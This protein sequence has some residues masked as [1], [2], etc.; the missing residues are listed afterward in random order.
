MC[1]NNPYPNLL[2]DF[3]KE[4][5]CD[6][7]FL[8][9]DPNRKNINSMVKR[10]LYGKTDIEYQYEYGLKFWQLYKN[11]RKF[12]MIVNN[13]GHEGTLEV[14]KYD[15]DIVFNFLNTLYNENLLRDTTILLLS[16]HGTPMPSV[17][18]F[19]EF[20]N[21]ERLL[22]MLFIMTSDKENLTYHNQYHNIYENQQKLVTAYDIYNTICY[23]MLGYNYF[24]ENNSKND[25][26][27]KSKFGISL[28]EPI[29]SKRKPSDYKKMRKNICS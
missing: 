3:S 15:D 2:K 13:D 8:L 18:N 14:I 28:F 20:Y 16:D 10:C 22:P 4:E 19:N 24:D 5:L 21:I 6:H 25:Y 9:C 27:F 7:E 29:N 1:Y 17:Y 23:L 11:N 26:I 12:L